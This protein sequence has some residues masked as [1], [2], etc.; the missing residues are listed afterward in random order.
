MAGIGGI[1]LYLKVTEDFMRLPFED[2]FVTGHKPF[3][4]MVKY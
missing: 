2:G 1:V 3:F 4:S